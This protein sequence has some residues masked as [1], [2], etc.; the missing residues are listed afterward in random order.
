MGVALVGLARGA[1]L[2]NSTLISLGFTPVA[3]YTPATNNTFCTGALQ[4]AQSCANLT[5]IVDITNTQ[6][7]TA[8]AWESAN[9]TS[10]LSNATS[11]IADFKTLCNITVIT[12]NVGKKL[13]NVTITQAMVDSCSN[14]S[15]LSAK[16][17]TNTANL[18]AQL[19][20]CTNMIATT[21]NGAYCLFISDIATTFAS[22]NG[23]AIQITAHSDVPNLVVNQCILPLYT[24]CY[25]N[26]LAG[27]LDQFTATVTANAA[28]TGACGNINT[29]A[30]C[31]SDNTACVAAKSALFTQFFTPTTSRIGALLSR[32]FGASVIAVRSYAVVTR[33][34]LM[35]Q[36]TNMTSSY[37]LSSTGFNVATTTTGLNTTNGTTPKSAAVYGLGF[38]L[39]LVAL[40]LN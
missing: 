22:V 26:S 20:S 4:N 35:A 30:T 38:L 40:V 2:G 31:T 10:A 5:R 28:L 14:L 27:F 9:F 19:S 29:M 36:P 6:K 12:A 18:T 32:S 8:L 24:A 33:R 13:N 16:A 7:T 11:A 25:L 3:P 37:Q 21:I 23:N 15:T 39:M 17:I 34:L 1:C